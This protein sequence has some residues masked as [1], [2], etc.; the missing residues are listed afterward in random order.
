ME[1]VSTGGPRPFGV[2]VKR[3]PKDYLL[4]AVDDGLPAAEVGPWAVEKYRRLGMYAEIFSTG[5]KNRWDCP[6][7][8][9]LFAG[10]G[11][12]F[13]RN[14]G[15]R[16]LTSPLLA[17]T[18]P[19]PFDKYILCDR[20]PQYVSAL[21]DRAAAVAPAA[22]VEFV[23]G[24]A[25]ASIAEVERRIPSHCLSFCFVDPFGVDIHFQAMRTLATG[26][27]MDFLVLRA[28]GMDAT[29]NWQLYIQPGNSKVERF[30]GDAT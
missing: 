2:G 23:V 18:V 21:R 8:I 1:R 10:P 19:D 24:D 27:A 30:L 15:H 14:A 9:D 5:M 12:A 26:R 22:S 7:Y 25:N 4:P 28:L 3:R 11:H 20:D 13:I 29:R 16:V 6:T 17:L